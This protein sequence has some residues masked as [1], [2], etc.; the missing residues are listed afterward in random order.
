[1][2]GINAEGKT[3]LLRVVEL[4]KKYQPDLVAVQ[5]VDSGMI[6]S[7]RLHQMRILSLLTGYNEFFGA[8]QQHGSG[9]EGL[10]V[11]SKWPI[12]ATQLL[13]L[14]HIDTTTAP[15]SLLCALLAL[16]QNK[17]CRFCNTMLDDFSP[18]NRGLQAAVVNEALQYSIQPVILAG[19][20]NVQPDDHTLEA[21]T[22][23]WNDAGRG[24]DAGT[25]EVTGKRIDYIWTLKTSKFK[26]LDYRVLY[27][28]NTSEHAPVIATY[29]LR[30]N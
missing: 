19:D 14:P 25:H 6:T 12:E 4:I 3:N 16:P 21:I 2:H 17:Y 28:P 27:E 24:T 23:Y 29:S 26:L 10:G 1:Q 22:K 7:G 15:R 30:F 18:L 5:E 8:V 20:F 9:K 11:L 13:K